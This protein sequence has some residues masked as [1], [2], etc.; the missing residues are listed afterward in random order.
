MNL[1]HA[2]SLLDIDVHILGSDPT[3]KKESKPV[4]TIKIKPNPVNADTRLLYSISTG[5][6]FPV[7]IYFRLK[8][9]YVLLKDYSTLYGL[10]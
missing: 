3:A 8:Q 4:N 1:C 6:Q 7:L 5:T 10:N 2:V 9:I